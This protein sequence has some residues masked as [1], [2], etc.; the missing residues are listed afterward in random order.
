MLLL[1]HGSRQRKP[2]RRT[3]GCSEFREA[4]DA[5]RAEEKGTESNSPEHFFDNRPGVGDEEEG[6]EEDEE[7][8]EA[9]EKLVEEVEDYLGRSDHDFNVLLD[10]FLERMQSEGAKGLEAER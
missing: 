4:V 5:R 7:V 1:H 9:E 10:T 8:W 3:R 2:S 6:E